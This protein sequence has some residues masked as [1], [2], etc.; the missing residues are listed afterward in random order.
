MSKLVL[1]FSLM[2]VL[3]ACGGAPVKPCPDPDPDPTSPCAT[4]HSQTHGG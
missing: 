4:S 1:L 3:A 2:F